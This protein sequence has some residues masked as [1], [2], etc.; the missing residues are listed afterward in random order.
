MKQ[1]RDFYT[2]TGLKTLSKSFIPLIFIAQ[3]VL[4]QNT[5][6]GQQLEFRKALPAA[7]SAENPATP[8]DLASAAAPA[9]GSSAAAASDKKQTQVKPETPATE[10]SA[11]PV[12]TETKKVENPEE[13]SAAEKKPAKEKAKPAQNK[14]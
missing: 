8:P 5:P 2:R 13:P 11:K 4:A 3:S 1:R 6:K 12:A 10:K 7:P 9:A 14:S